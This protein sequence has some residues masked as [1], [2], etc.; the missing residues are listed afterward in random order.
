MYTVR[1]YRCGNSLEHHPR[2]LRISLLAA[3]SCM[4]VAVPREAVASWTVVRLHPSTALESVALCVDENTQG[5]WTNTPNRGAVWAGTSASVTFV[6]TSWAVVKAMYGPDKAGKV[7][8]GAGHYRAALW[9]GAGNEFLDLRPAGAA[10]AAVLG[11]FG[12]IQVGETYWN[13]GSGQRSGYHATL[14]NGTAVS[15]QDLSPVGSSDSHLAGIDASGQ[16]GRFRTSVS[17]PYHAALWHGTAESVVDLHP[18]AAYASQAQAISNGRQGG[19]VQPVQNGYYR[20]ALWA[21]SAGSYSDLTPVNAYSSAI[22]G[23]DADIQAGATLFD[24]IA[25]PN[26]HATVW[27]GSAASVFD[28]HG[29]LSSDYTSSTAYAVDVDEFGTIRVVGS[30]YNNNN[31]LPNGTYYPRNEAMMWVLLPEPSSLA[32]LAAGLAGLAGVRP[33]RR[34]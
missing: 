19:W 34:K 8:D 16:A 27:W 33:R 2:T 28:L 6:D 5:G 17:A 14:W 31:Y 4:C 30:A 1:H 15:W 11:M 9:R 32:A 7:L 21:G 25:D 23:M 20:A 3:V 24:G 13:I 12:T 18:A 22:N 29:L 10:D 26:T